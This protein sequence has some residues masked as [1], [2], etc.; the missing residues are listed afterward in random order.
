MTWED[1]I[2]EEARVANRESLLKEDD[3]AM[4]SHTK[5]GRM[6][7][8]F[9][10]KI[11]KE[12]QPPK[13]LQRKRGNNQRKKYSNFQCF[14]CNKIGNIAIN[15]PLKKTEYKMNNKICHAHLAEGEV[16]EEEE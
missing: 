1:C 16:E 2:H 14:N 5:R 9:K 4:A 6:K 7:S 13:K 12:Y 10:K 11:H 15:C 3:Q 8:N